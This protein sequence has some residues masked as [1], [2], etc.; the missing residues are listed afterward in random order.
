MA[1]PSC[2][3]DAPVTGTVPDARLTQIRTVKISV[4]A[5]AGIDVNDL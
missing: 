1:S 4:L 3:R 2:C 5:S